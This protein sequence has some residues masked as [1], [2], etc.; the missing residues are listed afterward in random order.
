MKMKWFDQNEVVLPGSGW[1]TGEIQ[2]QSQEP[3]K[4]GSDRGA[5][6]K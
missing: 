5:Q 1:N 6:R 2:M 4:T 3:G